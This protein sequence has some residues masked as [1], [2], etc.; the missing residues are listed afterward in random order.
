[1]YL[2]KTVNKNV[3]GMNERH[4]HIHVHMSPEYIY[5]I[6]LLVYI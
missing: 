2:R 1:M 5:I 3:L 4:V 6:S